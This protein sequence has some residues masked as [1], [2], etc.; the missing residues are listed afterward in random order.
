MRASLRALSA[1]SRLAVASPQPR[2]PLPLLPSPSS[3]HVGRPSRPSLP[4]APVPW[5]LDG[6]PAASLPSTLLAL[7]GA[8]SLGLG[9]VVAM[10]A[11]ST[12]KKRKL[13]MNRH[14]YRK[15]LKRDRKRTK[16]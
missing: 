14:K 16:R 11:S 5:R 13:K 15:R 8:V 12:L 1:L 4:P 10:E 6:A 3:F 9:E 7:R 2:L